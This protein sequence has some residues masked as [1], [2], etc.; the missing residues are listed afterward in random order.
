MEGHTSLE[1]IINCQPDV[2]ILDLEMPGL[3]GIEIARE[4]MKYAPRPAIVICSVEH[5][6]EVVN[7]ALE[8]GAIG[9]VF[10]AGVTR[11]QI[12][13]VKAAARGQSF[14]SKD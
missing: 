5:D 8:S 10:K 13:A 14:V 11:D 3:N 12:T 9:Y 7:A 4:L 1:T 6:P 2:V